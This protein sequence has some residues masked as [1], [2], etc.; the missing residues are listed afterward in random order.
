M[1]CH[2]IARK[3]KFMKS[4][5]KLALCG[6]FGA[7]SVTVML[8]GSII[9][10]ATYMCPAIAAFFLLPVVYEY[11]EKT[12][13]TLYLVVSILSMLLV[14]EKEYAVMYAFVFGLYTVFKFKADKIKPK[15]LQYT[16]K[17]L[18][19]AVMTVACYSVMLFVFTSPAL[20]S[21]F[22]G[23]TVWLAVAFVVL[24][25]I[26]FVLYDIAAGKMFILY[27]YRLRPKLIKG[28]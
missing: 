20:L 24:F 2:Y 1:Y 5:K 13:F 7:L 9:P 19:A 28:R 22:E 14:A 26:T 12:A 17:A 23:M 6:V 8:L 15:I 21:D 4:T 18:Y 3:E 10:M 16:L 11:K 27:Y 25:T